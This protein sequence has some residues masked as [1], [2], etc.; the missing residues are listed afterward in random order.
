MTLFFISLSLSLCHSGF[1]VFWE[2]KRKTRGK[3]N[4][5]FRTDVGKGSNL[6]STA[7]KRK[8][9]KIAVQEEEETLGRKG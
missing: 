2:R 9:N 1:S 6:G 5:R 4:G 8:K 3:P 7:V